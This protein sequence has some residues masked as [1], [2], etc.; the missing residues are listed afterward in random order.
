MKKFYLIAAM[1]VA[2]LAAS[3]QEKLNLSTYNGTNIARYDGK[4]CDVTVN[5]YMFKGWNTIALPFAVSEEELNDIF[6]RD[7]KLERLVGAENEGSSICLNFMDSKATGIEANIPYILYYTGETGNKRIAKQALVAEQEPAISFE[8]KNGTVVT[9]GSAVTKID[10]MGLYGVLARDNAEA[11]FVKV[12]E[13]TNGFYATRC[14]VKLSSGNNQTITTRHLSRGEVTSIQA[15]AGAN[16]LVDV[17]N[18]AGKKIASKMSASEINNL[19]PAVY[20]VKGQKI[21]V[22]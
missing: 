18:T 2:T 19:K 14:F 12:D 4:V 7:C 5:R 6:G 11:R 15:V 9:M 22:K 10:G 17:Y 3:A 21:L 8:T 16:E 13:T 1:A 20:V